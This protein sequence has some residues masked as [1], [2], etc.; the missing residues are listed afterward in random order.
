[1]IKTSG[2]DHTINVL[3]AILSTDGKGRDGVVAV[4]ESLLVTGEPERVESLKQLAR[5]ALP[6]LEEGKR[7]RL[8]RFQRTTTV[9]EIKP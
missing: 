9:E 4:G 5:M 8:V 2:E 6:F 7:L 1:M 3:W